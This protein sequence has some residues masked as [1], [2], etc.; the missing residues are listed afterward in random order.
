MSL[1]NTKSVLAKLLASENI[2]IEHRSVQTACF[3]LASRTL[4]CPTWVD[5]DGDIYDLVMGHEVGHALETPAEGWHN[6]VVEKK[7]FKSYLNVIEDARI[8][9]KIK[10]RYPGLSRSFNSAYKQLSDRDFFGI[11]QLPDLDKLTLIDRINLRCKL[12]SHVVVQFN[13]AERALLRE[14]ENAETW[15]QVVDIAKRVY[16]Y[17]KEFE[18]D[19]I[20]DAKELQKA[21]NKAMKDLLPQD[22][23]EGEDESMEMDADY[24]DSEEAEDGEGETS[25]SEQSSDEED[26][27]DDSSSSDGEMDTES[28]SGD[29]EEEEGPESVTDKIFRQRESELVNASGRVVMIELP[30][31]DFKQ[32]LKTSENTLRDFEV[33]IRAELRDTTTP[34]GRSGMT[35]EKLA[36]LSVGKFNKNNRKYIT[37]ILKE[38]EMRKRASEYSRQQTART[39]ELNTNVLH[40]YKYSNDL[41]KKITV[42]PKGKN[43]GMIM[44]V[45]MSGSMQGIFRNTI[46]QL[47][48]L[49][50]FCKLANIPFDVYGFSNNVSRGVNALGL[51]DSSATK[52]PAVTGNE[53]IPRGYGFH[54]LHLLGS[55][56]NKPMYTRAFN[57]L[58]IIAAEYRNYS[59]HAYRE[60]ISMHA[61]NDAGFG[62]NSTPTVEMLLA[63]RKIITEFRAAT[64]ADV[65][66]VV[67]LTDGV[68]DGGWTM[69]KNTGFGMGFDPKSVHYLVDKTTKKKIRLPSHSSL[70]ATLTELVRDVTGCKH[71][72]FYLSPRSYMTRE[73]KYSSLPIEQIQKLKESAKNNNFFATPTLGYDT[74][75]YVGIDH[76]NVDDGK[77]EVDDK[78]TKGK[79]AAVFK[80]HQ[81]GKTSN[82]ILVSRFSAEIAA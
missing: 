48:V 20:N 2:N 62:L 28:G 27:S 8:E 63:S 58:A 14:T 66:N 41:F 19:K 4:T 34:Y 80:K 75:F 64:R 39:G 24:D 59:P 51:G 5:M 57:M 44:F 74:Y 46:E 60:N 76:G 54:L 11:R 68:G 22:E 55:G 12:G 42:I 7:K 77:L 13:D 52:F 43:H 37:H 25:D 45:D 18:M 23:E 35:Y 9:K 81:R 33:A 53:L 69:P 38:F 50:S 1:I 49:T 29:D 70:Q 36:A 40:K 56:L 10:R 65:V 21:I 6:A 17:S 61:W 71:I 30:E 47:L 78:M 72:G 67:H 82:R 16:S 26:D 79:I 3:D 31:P 32:I 73:L 15:E